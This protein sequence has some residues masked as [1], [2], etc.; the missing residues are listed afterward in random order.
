MFDTE[1]AE[2]KDNENQTSRYIP[3]SLKKKSDNI[4]QTVRYILRSENPIPTPKAV[5]EDEPP[6]DHPSEP[7]SEPPSPGKNLNQAEDGNGGIHLN[8]HQNLH[9][10][11]HQNL[12]HLN[13]SR[14]REGILKNKTNTWKIMDSWLGLRDL[15]HLMVMRNLHQ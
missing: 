13:Q 7:P 10:Y 11:I 6:S 5:S 1:D 2:L 15:L 9:Q 3:G 4:N 12:H 14:K 8:Q